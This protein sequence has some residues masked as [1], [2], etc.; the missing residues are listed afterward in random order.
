[1]MTALCS[2][3]NNGGDSDCLF[4][5]KLASPTPLPQQKFVLV[6]LFPWLILLGYSYC[7]HVHALILQ[8]NNSMFDHFMNIKWLQLVDPGCCAVGITMLTTA[9]LC[10]PRTNVLDFCWLKNLQ[11]RDGVGSVAFFG[12]ASLLLVRLSVRIPPFLS[13]CGCAYFNLCRKCW[14]WA[15]RRVII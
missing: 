6:Y 13:F 15:K 10:D 12:C 3:E 7:R 11:N 14:H 4:I 1:M 9:L 5:L 2:R 8:P